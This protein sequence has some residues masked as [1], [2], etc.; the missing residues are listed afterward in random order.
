[1]LTSL[2]EGSVDGDATPKANIPTEG[3]NNTCKLCIVHKGTLEK[4]LAL[5]QQAEAEQYPLNGSYS[6]QTKTLLQEAMKRIEQIQPCVWLRTIRLL[7][8][9][10]DEE[11]DRLAPVTNPGEVRVAVSVPNK[12]DQ[13]PCDRC[14]N[15]YSKLLRCGRCKKANYCGVECQKQDWAKHKPNCHPPS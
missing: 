7:S 10:D 1:M 9:K 12:P 3:T 2:S 13:Q 8:T 6:S 4:C 11:L 15:Y 5:C 14:G